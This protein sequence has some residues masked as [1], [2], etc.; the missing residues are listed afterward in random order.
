MNNARVADLGPPLV[1]DGQLQIQRVATLYVLP[2]ENLK[3]S[4]R[5]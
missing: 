5:T 4:R 3:A 2:T 1:V